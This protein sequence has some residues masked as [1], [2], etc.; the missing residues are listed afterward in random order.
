[1]GVETTKNTG[2]GQFYT[3]INLAGRNT[4]LSNVSGHINELVVISR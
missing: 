4:G 2:L 3:F 1:M